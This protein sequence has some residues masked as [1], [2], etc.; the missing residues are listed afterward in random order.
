MSAYGNAVKKIKA[1]STDIEV[2][3]ERGCI[4]L[5]GEADKWSTAVKAGQ[6]V[7]NKKKYLGVINDI[8]L[9]G[10]VEQQSLP[11]ENDRS[12]EGAHPDVLIIGGGI[13]GCAIAREL[14][15]WKL[16]ILLVE[17]GPDVAVGASRANGGVIHVGVNFPRTSQKH[18]YNLRG[19][20]MYAELSR[21]M[22]V[23]F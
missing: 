10:F 16:D 8:K 20:G 22:G 18:F 4:V 17:K 2:T 6:L 23:P 11:S 12:L 19:N 5:R 14:A 3:E 15:R 1:L 13:V 7:V 21:Q 9:R